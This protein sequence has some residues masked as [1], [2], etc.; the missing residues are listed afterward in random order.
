MES[1]RILWRAAAANSL[2]PAR[3]RARYSSCGA[4]QS[5]HK[6]GSHGRAALDPLHGSA[7]VQMVDIASHAALDHLRI[8]FIKLR[9]A[10]QFKAVTDLLPAHSGIAYAEILLK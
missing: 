3:L 2:F 9:C 10:H 5:G 8:A 7:G 4:I 1:A 6:Q